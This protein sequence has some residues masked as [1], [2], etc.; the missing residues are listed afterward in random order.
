MSQLSKPI[1]IVSQIDPTWRDYNGHVNYAAYAMAADPAID[2][3]YAAAGLDW[4]YRK[5]QSRS[6]Y[7][8]E[9]RFFY[10]REIR[11][12]GKIE[13]RARLVDF[14][15]KR[16]HIYCEIRDHDN[17]SLSATAH[18]VSLHVD[19]A[20]AKSAEFEDFALEGFAALKAEHDQLPV[21]DIFDDTVTLTRRLGRARAAPAA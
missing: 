9:S 10:L 20:K 18:I 2:A 8:V 19:S 4:N 21:P 17:G 12:G 6:D 16:T 15:R 5:R 13:V 11:S 1:V 14:D 7:V 3:I